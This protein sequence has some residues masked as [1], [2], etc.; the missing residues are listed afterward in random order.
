[1]KFQKEENKER[2]DHGRG[3][4]K[5]QIPDPGTSPPTASEKGEEPAPCRVTRQRGCFLRGSCRIGDLGRVIKWNL[6]GFRADPVLPFPDR[7]VA[8]RRELQ[9]RISNLPRGG[10][11]RRFAGCEPDFGCRRL[12]PSRILSRCTRFLGIHVCA[13]CWQV[14][15]RTQDRRDGTGTFWFPRAAGQ[16]N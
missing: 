14:A 7:L 13:A 4:E 12:R 11:Y 16:E 8:G 15:E 3:R 9:A 1:M 10:G 5:D 6:R 2:G